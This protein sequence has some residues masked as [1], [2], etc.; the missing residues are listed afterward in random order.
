MLVGLLQLVHLFWPINRSVSPLSL[1]QLVW[2]LCAGCILL[3]RGFCKQ[4]TLELVLG[5]GVADHSNPRGR[6]HLL[7]F[8]PV[9]N[10][11]CTKAM[12]HYDLGL[13]YLNF[14]AGRK[15]FPLVPGLVNV[16]EHLALNQSV[17]SVIALV[18][19]LL[20]HRWGVFLVGGFLPWLGLT[21]SLFASCA[22]DSSDVLR[23][24]EQCHAHWRSPTPSRCRLG[25][26]RS[27]MPIFQAH[28]RTASFLA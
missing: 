10:T 28:L 11:V 2:L 16:Q 4:W 19:S 25:C 26:L 1:S 5:A 9:F 13:Y 23:K 24:K 3:I 15:N 21:L 6:F 18:D 14:F 8:Y 27:P 12:C 20:P 22:L 17:F 7:Y